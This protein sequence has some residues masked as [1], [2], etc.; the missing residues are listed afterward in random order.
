M[1]L[2]PAI[3]LMG[4]QVVRLRQGDASAKT[5]YS[6]DPVGFARRWEEEGGD[7]LHVVDLDG[8]FTGA[9]ANLATIKEIASALTIPVEVGGGIRDKRTA[10]AVLGAGV[11][12]VIIGTRAVEAMEFVE[13]LISSCGAESVAVGIDAR[14]GVAAVKGWTESGGIPAVELARRAEQAGAQTIIYTDIAT[15]GMLEGPNFAEIEKIR[16][17]VRCDVI[18]SGGVSQL[19][20]VRRLAVMGGIHGAIIGKALF[21]GRIELRE[22][23]TLVRGLRDLNSTTT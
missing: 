6:D 7:F 23:A 15:D 13:N 2:L 12:R 16:D 22:A 17:A 3:D 4:G 11:R 18:A 9:P 5:V 20:D 14:N 1:I 10:E 19:D 8:A 21:D